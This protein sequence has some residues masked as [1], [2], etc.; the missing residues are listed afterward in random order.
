MFVKNTWYVAAWS[1]EL[2]AGKLLAR[3]LLG[4]P[5]V[6]YR[7]EDGRAVA[8]EDRCPHRAAPLSL[9]RCEGDN[10]R[11]MYHG[12]LFAPSG[13]CLELPHHDR[14]P[15]MQARTCPVI[16]RDRLVWIWCGDPDKAKATQPE[17][18]H[19][20]SS[21]QW[22]GTPGYMH[23]KADYQLIADNLLDFTHS[24]YVHQTT[25]GSDAVA[26]NQQGVKRVG[27]RVRVTRHLGGIDPV[28]FHA[29][30]GK[31][32]GKVDMWQEY[33]WIAPNILSM[34]AGSA[35]TGT[36]AFEGKR[37]HAPVR[38]RH[39]SLLTPETATTTHYFFVQLRNF[40]LD[41][42]GMDDLIFGQVS[43]AFAEDQAMIEAQ[44]RTIDATPG[45]PLGTMAV[46]RGLVEVR[47]IVAEKLAAEQQGASGA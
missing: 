44:Q 13:E 39:L 1:H 34:D 2:A 45:R 35:D 30:S 12:L 42:P 31:F 40:A 14:P 6:L 20:L 23:Y 41:D 16:E 47:R 36:G 25:F 4:E 27:D 24:A 8:M 18:C 22:R 46:D 38:F 37:E 21:S 10:I 3:T 11:C 7:T 17:D 28:P 15:R 5:V 9:G 19:W 32:A 33:D 26:A 29:K 43:T